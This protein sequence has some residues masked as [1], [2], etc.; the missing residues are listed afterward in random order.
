[1]AAIVLLSCGKSKQN[2]PCKAEDMYTGA[3]FQKS[4][5]VAK[6]MRPNAIYIL[7][8]KY[9]LLPL[10]KQIVPY[11][12]TLNAFTEAQKKNW[13][14]MVLRQLKSAG[15]TDKDTLIFLTGEN[16]PKY[17]M[18]LHLNTKCPIK[19]LKLGE[20]LSLYNKILQK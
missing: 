17:L 13:A 3:L 2:H 15:V 14:N 8:A 18:R 6:K 10:N 16:Y 11:N 19:A 5:Q 20:Q 4:L 7:S 9:G 1:M 12:V